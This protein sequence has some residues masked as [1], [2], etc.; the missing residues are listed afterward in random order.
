MPPGTGSPTPGSDPSPS[1]TKTAAPKSELLTNL[2]PVAQ[3]DGYP[4]PNYLSVGSAV[5]DTVHYGYGHA[6]VFTP[7][8]DYP[9]PCAYVD[10]FSE[11]NLDRSWKK[12]TMAV[13]V[14]DTSPN[15]TAEITVSLDGK[16]LS[17]EQVGVGKPE[18]LSLNVAN[19]LRLRIT[20]N[21]ADSPGHGCKLGN[22]VIGNPT[23]T[24]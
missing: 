24:R 3:G 16:I 7:S 11:Y 4:T 1:S 10:G 2:H 8:T 18:P 19:G 14:S 17:K 23:L 6:L 5:M 20:F 12:L 21:G 13:G 15:H 9:L 22:V